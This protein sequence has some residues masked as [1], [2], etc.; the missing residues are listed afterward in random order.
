MESQAYGVAKENVDPY[1]LI[2][3]QEYMEKPNVNRPAITFTSISGIS[4]QNLQR[5]KV[6]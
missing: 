6:N 5:I 3:W 1:D 2:S 4:G